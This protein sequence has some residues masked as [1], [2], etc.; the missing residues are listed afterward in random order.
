MAGP[1]NM[2]I[3]GVLATRWLPDLHLVGPGQQ[4][5]TIPHKKQSC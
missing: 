2:A 1:S 4:T 3:F 5:R